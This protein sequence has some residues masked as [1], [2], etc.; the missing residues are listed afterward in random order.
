MVAY[1][2]SWLLGLFQLVLVARVVVDWIDV[3]GSGRGG[4]VLDTARRVTHGLTEPVVGSFVRAV[5][6]TSDGADL[7][8]AP[9]AAR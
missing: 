1:L 8:A 9:G 3:L 5:V 6:V 2:L 4:A 7:V